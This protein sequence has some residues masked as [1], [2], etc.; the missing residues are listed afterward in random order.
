MGWLDKEQAIYPDGTISAYYSC[1]RSIARGLGGI[2]RSEEKDS[3]WEQN[4]GWGGV[5]A[6]T[7]NI[8]RNRMNCVILEMKA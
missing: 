4:A 8:D 6:A 2:Y 5:A 1:N 7:E 3:L